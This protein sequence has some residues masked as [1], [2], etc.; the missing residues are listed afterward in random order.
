MSIELLTPQNAVKWK[1]VVDS[2]SRR[3]QEL[4][5]SEEMP[6]FL[7]LSNHWA[8]SHNEEKCREC[9]SILTRCAKYH[10][11]DKK[12]LEQLKTFKSICSIYFVNNGEEG[13]YLF[14]RELKNIGVSSP[15]PIPPPQP[16]SPPARTGQGYE[17]ITYN[18]G[19]YKGQL[20]N[21]VP[22]GVGCLTLPNGDTYEGQWVNGGLTGQGTIRIAETGRR[23]I[24]EYNNGERVGRGRIEWVNG[25]RLEGEWNNQGLH[26]RGTEYFLDR[27]KYT[28]MFVN[29]VRHGCGIITMPDGRKIEYEYLNGELVQPRASHSTPLVTTTTSTRPQP[30]PQRPITPKRN[31]VKR[32]FLISLII[33]GVCYV[34]V[35]YAPVLLDVPKQEPQIATAVDSTLIKQREGSIK[36]T[37]KKKVVRKEKKVAV[38]SEKVF[39]DQLK[40]RKDVIITPSGLMYEVISIGSGAQPQ[41]T[42]K[43]KVRYKGEGIDG[44]VFY[45]RTDEAMEFE[46]DRVIKGWTEGVQLMR[47]GSKY[48]FYTPSYLA[49]G[50]QGDGN[51]IPP[52]AA[53]IFEVEL[54]SVAGEGT[55][56]KK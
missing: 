53:I 43:V 7:Y 44:K 48:R 30:T 47:V 34:G 3:V 40:E 16:T 14:V 26:G 11:G 1:Q 51:T 21:G 17:T 33:G 15:L 49:Y 10:T 18:G 50:E 5:A 8:E 52:N 4:E 24:G 42:S 36:A 55:G 37:E 56:D 32:I 46:L 25:E 20:S 38:N 6:A 54:L 22:H 13:F 35:N 12:F 39:F 27:S 2:I 9:I 31:G 41:A 19:T 29:G 45:K 23:E 28:G